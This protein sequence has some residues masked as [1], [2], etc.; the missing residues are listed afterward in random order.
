MRLLW[1][2]ER[3]NK[4]K[5]SINLIWCISSFRVYCVLSACMCIWF[6]LGTATTSTVQHINF[7]LFNH[8]L[9][10]LFVFLNH[11]VIMPSKYFQTITSFMAL[12][13]SVMVCSLTTFGSCS[14]ILFVFGGAFWTCSTLFKFNRSNWINAGKCSKLF[15]C[16]HFVAFSPTNYFLN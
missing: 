8:L 16:T 6:G 15:W 14:I 11:V 12:S 1:W 4:R 2:N 13:R 7:I 5:N 9:I 3:T 10:V